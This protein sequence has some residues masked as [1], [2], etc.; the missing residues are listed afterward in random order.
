[1]RDIAFSGF[2]L[3]AAEWESMDV[4]ARWQL[5]AVVMRRDEPWLAAA[6]VM[7]ATGPENDEYE[8]Y[9]LSYA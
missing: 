1:M 5:L 6:P 2:V 7:A 8:S 4:M 3:T 9:Q